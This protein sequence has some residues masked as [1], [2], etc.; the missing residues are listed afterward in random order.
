MFI[1][2]H[3]RQ[4]PTTITHRRSYLCD[5]E[6]AGGAGEDDGCW[7]ETMVQEWGRP[8]QTSGSVV[9]WRLSA[10][11]DIP[12]GSDYLISYDPELV[13]CYWPDRDVWLYE[14]QMYG[15]AKSF[16]NLLQFTHLTVLTRYI[17]LLITR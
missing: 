15:Y 14:K 7:S 2:P 10:D 13:V 4:L 6:C 8:A 1:T 3:Q 17:R 11:N 5:C 9:R 12:R 16:F